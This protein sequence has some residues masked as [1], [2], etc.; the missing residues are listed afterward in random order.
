M[1]NIQIENG[2]NRLKRI[3]IKSKMDLKS[4]YRHKM[5]NESKWGAKMKQMLFKMGSKNESHCCKHES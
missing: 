2:S 1:K 5:K 4:R 3:K